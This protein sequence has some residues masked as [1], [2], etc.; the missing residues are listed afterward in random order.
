MLG[1]L[2]NNSGTSLGQRG[3][4]NYVEMPSTPASLPSVPSFGTE[5]WRHVRFNAL[6]DESTTS[7]SPTSS[8]FPG[9]ASTNSSA[10]GVGTLQI[11]RL[12]TLIP[13]CREARVRIRRHRFLQ[14]ALKYLGVL[15]PCCSRLPRKSNWLNCTQ[16]GTQ[17]SSLRTLLW[18]SSRKTKR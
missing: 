6:A 4:N 13:H 16:K 2:L 9:F 18:P 17:S 8:S 10:I 7:A 12:R 14:R 15:G 11:A 1:P 5:E 3:E